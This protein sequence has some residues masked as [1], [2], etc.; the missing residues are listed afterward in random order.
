MARPER[1][2]WYFITVSDADLWYVQKIRCWRRI[3]DIPA[4]LGTRSSA[5][6]YT[7]VGAL[8]QVR[9]AASAGAAEVVATRRVNRRSRKY[10][11]GY[12]QE[13]HYAFP[14]NAREE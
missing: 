10:P 14:T 11:D 5:R 9:K 6:A 2:V 1:K 13:F 7:M 4:G 3:D 8:R 12:F